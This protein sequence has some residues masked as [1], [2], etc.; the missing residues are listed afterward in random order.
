[1]S[2]WRLISAIGLVVPLLVAMALWASAENRKTQRLEE[3][4]EELQK[5]IIHAR[6][7]LV[8]LNSEWAYINNHEWVATLADE[9]FDE[10]ELSPATGKSF[11]NVN[12]IPFRYQISTVIDNSSELLIAVPT[13]AALQ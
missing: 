12:S 8:T 6:Q 7:K 3:V 13:S 1:M 2:D 9:H 4:A 5:K 11:K 10:L